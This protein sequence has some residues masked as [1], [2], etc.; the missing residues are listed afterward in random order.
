[1][2]HQA[3]CKT[4]LLLLTLCIGTA[5][6]AAEPE[7][8][9]ATED[10]EPSGIE[11]NHLRSIPCV[12]PGT[13]FVFSPLGVC[14]GITGD[15]YV[16]DSDNSEIYVLSDSLTA[17]MPFADCPEEYG[18]CH[19]ADVAADA[20]AGIYVSERATGTVMVFDRRG[21][22]VSSSE[23][24]EG[25]TGIGVGRS[26]E[27]YAAM[28]AMGTVMVIDPSGDGEGLEYVIADTGDAYPIDCLIDPVG[29]LIVTE[30]FSKRVLVLGPLGEKR[31]WLRGF[32]FEDPFGLA[33]C[34][35]GLVLVSDTEIGVVALFDE[36]GGFVTSFGSDVLQSPTF[37]DCRHD[38][39]VC[40][41]DTDRM[42]IEVFKIEKPAPE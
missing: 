21:S 33:A 19:F 14:F 35:K 3:T 30:P 6:P 18:R 40:V 28:S 1:M 16:I 11:V 8:K 17:I 42:T 4:L 41:A 7:T 39:I 38:G 26:G 22:F 20:S 25:V 37:L 12:Q 36:R 5:V 23:V 10:T 13:D 29:R 31:G 32:D 34:G 24:G 27:M 15:L 9:A 2:T